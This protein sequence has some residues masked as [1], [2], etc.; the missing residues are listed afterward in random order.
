MFTM[1]QLPIGIKTQEQNFGIAVAGIRSA[2]E[3][4]Q[5]DFAERLTEKGMPVD[6]SAVSRIEKGSRSV[7]LVEAM[8]IAEVLGVSLDF[9]I[10]G[11]RTPSQ[12]FAQIRE[13]ADRALHDLRAPV[14]TA[15]YHLWEANYYLHQQPELLSDLSAGGADGPS[16]VDDYLQW[17]A[18]RV[19]EWPIIEDDYI[20]TEV[21]FE[22]DGI[23]KV[24]I[25]LLELH[26]GLN[27]SV[28]EE[29][30]DGVDQETP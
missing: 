18:K 12:E 30:D 28:G 9:L 13:A 23:A 17:V 1:Q 26:I 6:A 2:R 7:R 10:G 4:S 14:A 27:F 22:E 24:L 11:A 3:L 20:R 8:T 15:A 25:K 16:H 19:G 29:G 5:R 21:P